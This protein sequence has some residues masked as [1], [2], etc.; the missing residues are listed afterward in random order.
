MEKNT[1]FVDNE[2]CEERIELE[3]SCEIRDSVQNI[4]GTTRDLSTH[5]ISVWFDKPYDIDDDE[6]ISITL[7]ADEIESTVQAR[8]IGTE[9]DE[10]GDRWKFVF[11]LES[12]EVG[13]ADYQKVIQ[14]AKQHGTVSKND[15]DDGRYLRKIR[16]YIYRKMARTHV[17]Q[18]V[19][20]QTALGDGKGSVFVSNYNYKYIL[21][22]Q[23]GSP[24]EYIKL[25][26]VMALFLDCRLVRQMAENQYLYEIENYHELRKDNIKRNLLYDWVVQN[27]ELFIY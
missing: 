3:L 15:A 7:R 18:N 13:K 24:Q 25:M 8:T 2:R 22:K 11:L 14:Y 26:P 23:E 27:E 21:I 5:A 10:N 9:K 20:R 12:G 6:I 4:K 16:N 17:E 19:E 1:L